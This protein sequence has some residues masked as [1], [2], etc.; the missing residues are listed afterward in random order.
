[1]SQ[2]PHVLK[3]HLNNG[4]PL[5]KLVEAVSD[6]TTMANLEFDSNG[7]STQSMELA[8]C[9]LVE[10]FLPVG[11]FD[12]YECGRRLSLGMNLKTLRKVGSV[13]SSF[14]FFL[15]LLWS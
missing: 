15:F 12:E 5:R 1:M 10:I 14:V 3:A 11:C 6:F 13:S 4:D 7:F 2:A 9:A 8:H